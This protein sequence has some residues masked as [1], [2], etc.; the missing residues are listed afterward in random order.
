MQAAGDLRQIGAVA[1]GEREL[2][3][4]G[5]VGRCAAMRV[6]DSRPAAATAASDRAA[7]GGGA[8]LSPGGARFCT[9]G[10]CVGNVGGRTDGREIEK[11][12]VGVA[13]GIAGECAKQYPHS[14]N[15]TRLRGPLWSFPSPSTRFFD[16]NLGEF[17]PSEWMVTGRPLW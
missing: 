16:R 7:R 17:K 11:L 2:R 9:G 13:G 10:F 6:P 1:G 14:P 3:L 5:A 12:R 4:R 8:A 15:Q